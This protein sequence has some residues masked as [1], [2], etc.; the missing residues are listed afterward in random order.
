MKKKS[1]KGFHGGKKGI[2]K[3]GAFGVK[4]AFTPSSSPFMGKKKGKK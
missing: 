2:D 1:M 4:Q 3:G